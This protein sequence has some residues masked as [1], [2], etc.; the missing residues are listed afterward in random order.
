LI[1]WFETNGRHDLPWQRDATPYS[2]WVSEIMLQQTRVTTVVPYFLRFMARFPSV[3]ALATARLDEVLTLWSGLGYYARARNL[4]RAART[5]V[6]EFDGRLP[7]SLDA[8]L[9]LPGIGRSTAG[10]ILA[11]ARGQRFAILDGN[12]KRVLARYHAVAGW[13]GKADVKRRLWEL[14]EAHTPRRR[15]AEYTQAIMDLGATVCLRRQPLCAACPLG[16]GCAA[17][18]AGTQDRLPAARAARERPR[19]SVRVLLVRDDDR[20]V[21]LERR[22]AS[23]IWGGLFSFPELGVE[24]E[25][26]Q[27]CDLNLGVSL[28]RSFP[29]A[30]LEHSFTHFDL[31]LDPLV[32][33]LAQPPRRLMERDDW[34]WYNLAEELHVGVAAPI[35]TLLVSL[36]D[37]QECCG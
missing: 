33:D 8:L 1:A 5:V 13:A 10:A 18:L 9:A 6:A 4:H 37:T 27:W 15:V 2:V 24:E 35:A 21:L 20:R 3:D 11:L 31:R 26:D 32:V 22:P 34:L 16:G 23:G 29:L 7:E 19:R 14:A 17:R 30:A 28:S 12:V 36:A 25:P